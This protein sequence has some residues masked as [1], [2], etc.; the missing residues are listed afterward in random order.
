[1][2]QPSP[3]WMPDIHADRQPF[4]RA[5]WRILAAL[6]CHLEEPDFI[7]VETAILQHSPGNETHLHAF[8]TELVAPDLAQSRFYLRTSPEFACKKL[9]AAGERRIFEFARGFPK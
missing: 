7:E 4:L 2:P 8:A 9:L 1:M 5:R 3:W 6:R